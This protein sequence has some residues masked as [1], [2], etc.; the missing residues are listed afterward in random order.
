LRIFGLKTDPKSA[1]SGQDSCTRV[2]NLEEY[3]DL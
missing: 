1:V 2:R 3:G